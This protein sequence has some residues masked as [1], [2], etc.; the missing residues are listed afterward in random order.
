MI[1]IR[2]AAGWLLVCCLAIHPAARG[3]GGERAGQEPAAVLAAVDTRPAEGSRDGSAEAVP[4]YTVG[5]GDVV[6]VDVDDHPDL[7]GEFTV[8]ADGRID[9]PLLG[10]VPIAGLSVVEV[11]EILRERLERDYLHLALVT[12]RIKEHRSRK[13]EIRGDVGKPGI[14]YLDGP[15]RLLDLLVRADGVANQL[16]NPTSR[17][18]A[19]IVMPADRPGPDGG[20]ENGGAEAGDREFVTAHV[21]LHE[22]LVEGRKE[23]NLLLYDGWVVYVPPILDEESTVHVLG[24][25]NGPGTL[26][27]EDG[28]TV[29]RAIALARGATKKAVLKK[30]FVTRERDG[31]ILEIPVRMESLLQP[32]DILTI[33]TS[34]W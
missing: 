21:D 7:A 13:V 4:V 22:L 14:Y 20:P 24:E 23:A 12:A 11:D 29:L 8:D 5:P 27:Y 25:V 6:E 34:F 2:S 16:D 19:R 1:A 26:A 15:L 31:E 18:Q 32:G 30:A 28:M 33:P 3:T 17:R 10:H 9:F